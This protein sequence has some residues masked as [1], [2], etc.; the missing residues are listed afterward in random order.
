MRTAAAAGR[1]PGGLADHECL[2]PV[3]LPRPGERANAVHTRALEFA[4]EVAG[5]AGA[6]GVIPEVAGIAARDGSSGLIRAARRLH[7]HLG[8]P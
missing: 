7:E 1:P 3:F 4:A 5:W 6:R 8:R 2:L